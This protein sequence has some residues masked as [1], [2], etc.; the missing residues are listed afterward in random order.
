MKQAYSNITSSEITKCLIA[1]AQPVNAEAFDIMSV[2]NGMLN[3]SKAVD[4]AIV[5]NPNP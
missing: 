4:C 5:L 1:A 3:S 2:G